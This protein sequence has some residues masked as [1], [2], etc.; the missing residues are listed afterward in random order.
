[1]KFDFFYFI[2]FKFFAALMIKLA[3]FKIQTVKFEFK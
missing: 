2:F 1:M 3:N